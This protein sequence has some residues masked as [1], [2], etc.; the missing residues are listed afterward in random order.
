[1][2]DAIYR[3]NRS[4]HNIKLYVQTGRIMASTKKKKDRTF[5]FSNKQL[6]FKLSYQFTF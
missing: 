6:W 3:I 4:L 1:M 2:L 5:I